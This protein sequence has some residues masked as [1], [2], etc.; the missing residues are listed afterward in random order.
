MLWLSRLL[1]WSFF[2]AALLV[3]GLGGAGYWV[4]RDSL[5]SGP[6]AESRTVVIRPHTGIA[7]MAHLL[8]ENGVIRHELAFEVVARLSAHAGALKAGEYEFPAGASTMQ[9]LDILASGKTVKHRL[10]IPEGLTS[11]EIVALV[12][13]AP[14]LDGEVGPVPGDGELLPDTYVYAYGDSRAGLIERMQ[15][16]MTHAVAQLWHD[17]RPD[18]PLTDPAEAVI[19]ASII[20]K[21]TAREEE[22]PHIAGVYIN[23]LRLGMRL[24]ADPTVIYALSRDG[25]KVD[26]PLS[27]ADLTLNSP[28]NTYAVKGLPPGPIDNPGKSSLRAAMRPE[29]T[30]DLYFVADG[31]GGHIFAKTLADQNRNV[32]QY[33]RS[34]AADPNAAPTPADPPPEPPAPRAAAPDP[35]AAP[36][37]GRAAQQ[38]SH[39]RHCRHEAG[40]GCIR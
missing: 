27:H 28:Y 35:A 38:A 39:P 29:H 12:R 20:E 36:P 5:R 40:R 30:E 25:G 7:G 13:D 1:A 18:L 8:A 15:R 24:Q 3:T 22:R 23:R 16:D 26:R 17:R 6:L 21:E 2:A 4:Y 14:V 19:L 9:T 31:S 10:T 11:A 33:R 37:P 34:A 32:A